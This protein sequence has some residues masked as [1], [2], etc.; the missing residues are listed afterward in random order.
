[1]PLNNYGLFTYFF[2]H[3]LCL[4]FVMAEY[5]VGVNHSFPSIKLAY[6]KAELFILFLFSP[7]SIY[8]LDTEKYSLKYILAIKI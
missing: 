2:F 4:H 6:C 5:T 3:T 8:I 1:M 7:I